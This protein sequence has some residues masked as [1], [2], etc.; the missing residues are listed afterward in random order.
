ME[1]RA[2]LRFLEKECGQCESKWKGCCGC[3]TR[4]LIVKTGSSAGWQIPNQCSVVRMAIGP[5]PAPWSV[6]GL[7]ESAR[8]EENC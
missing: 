6:E 4:E 1:N 5:R 8:C 7:G 3:S 2:G